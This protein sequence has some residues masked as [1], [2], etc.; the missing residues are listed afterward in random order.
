MGEF[1][2]PM[3]GS[4]VQ[5]PEFYSFE[6]L[7]KKRI[8]H[9]KCYEQLQRRLARLWDILIGPENESAH[10]RNRPPGPVGLGANRSAGQAMAPTWSYQSNAIAPTFSI[11]IR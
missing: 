8:Y 9:R 6:F 5:E 2:C 4:I 10:A 3:C 7:G 1:N 11:L